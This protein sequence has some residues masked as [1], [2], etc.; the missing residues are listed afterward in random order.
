LIGLPKGLLG[1]HK[2][3][4]TLQLKAYIVVKY[5]LLGGVPQCPIIKSTHVTCDR[6][7]A[8]CA[9]V[10]AELAAELAPR[11]PM[12]RMY[13]NDLAHIIDEINKLKRYAASN[14]RP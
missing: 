3:I 8:A 14:G 13:V 1:H 5:A 4:V 6:I 11:G 10:R 9:Q 12:E 7:G 2:T